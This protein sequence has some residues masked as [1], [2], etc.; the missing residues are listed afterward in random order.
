QLDPSLSA[1]FAGTPEVSKVYTLEGGWASATRGAG[2]WSGLLTEIVDGK[3]YWVYATAN[4][5]LTLHPKPPDPLALPPSYSL[6]E[7][8]H[9]IGYTSS[10]TT[11]PV[12]TYLSTLQG[13]WTSIYRYDVA[14]GWEVAKPGGLG[15]SHVEL[16][17]GYWM[18]LTSAGTLVP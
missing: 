7:G 3:G 18:Y 16:G 12:Q 17:R 1:V 6:T 10:L 5:T 2:G 13:K 9:L 8:W 15:F 4:T 14:K 11:M